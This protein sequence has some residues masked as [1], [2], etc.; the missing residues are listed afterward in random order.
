MGSLGQSVNA[1]PLVPSISVLAYPRLNNEPCPRGLAQSASISGSELRIFFCPFPSLSLCCRPRI[2]SSEWLGELGVVVERLSA[3][4]TL[5]KTT[6]A[7][8]T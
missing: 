2:G 5:P 8:Q 7:L 4:Q 3:R 6:L 1:V